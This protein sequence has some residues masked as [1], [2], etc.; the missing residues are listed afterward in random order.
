M[1]EKGDKLTVGGGAGGVA[2]W[3]GCPGADR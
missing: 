1:S 3:I 2:G